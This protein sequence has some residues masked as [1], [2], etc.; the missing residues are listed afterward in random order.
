MSAGL[1]VFDAPVRYGYGPHDRGSK[2]DQLRTIQTNYITQLDLS[3]QNIESLIQTNY[4][5]MYSAIGAKRVFDHGNYLT[6]STYFMKALHEQL[7][8]LVVTR[9]NVVNQDLE[10]LARGE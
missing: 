4:G 8:T 3:I 1:V 9:M 10:S 7:H 5:E 2:L 6:S